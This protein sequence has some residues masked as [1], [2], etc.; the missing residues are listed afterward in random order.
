MKKSHLGIAAAVLA[1]VA[2]LLYLTLGGKDD[3][4]KAKS[5]GTAAAGGDGAGAGTPGQPGQAGG[6]NEFMPRDDRTAP[7]LDAEG[8]PVRQPRK[9]APTSAPLAEGDTPQLLDPTAGQFD[10]GVA[11]D[12]RA[13]T[14]EG[15]IPV[16]YVFRADRRAVTGTGDILFTLMAAKGGDVAGA[17]KLPLEILGGSVRSMGDGGASGEPLALNDD[18]TGG[19]A[20]AG[21]H[22]YSARLNPAK[23]K[24]IKAT[25]FYE[26]DVQFQG[27]DGKANEAKVTFQ[28]TSKQDVPAVFTG[29]VSD[30][31]RNGALVAT[32]ELDVKTEGMF[33][34]G[35]NLYD[36]AGR[37]LARAQARRPMPSKGKNTIDVV[38]QGLIFHEA[39]RPGPYVVRHVHGYMETSDPWP[40][41]RAEIAPLVGEHKTQ[42]YKVEDFSSK[43]WEQQPTR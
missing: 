6:P 13:A 11:G 18:G 37:P 1:A 7:I 38:F 35:A 20:V 10:E 33:H 31:V 15:E 17:N 21:D 16:K 3:G 42:P 4:G 19:D 40:A 41:N 25:G 30:S 36:T 12:P 23:A 27:A 39:G 22:L 8:K 32:V 5:G 14:K 24:S 29:K 9:Y 43:A 2:V 34:V 28:Y 26:A